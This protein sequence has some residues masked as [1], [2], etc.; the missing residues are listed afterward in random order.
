MAWLT[1]PWRRVVAG[2]GLVGL[3]AGG[4]FYSQAWPLSG[5]GKYVIIQVTPGESVS[6]LG[7]DLA[8]HKVIGSTLAFRL[9]TAVFGSPT[10]AT[11]FYSIAQNSS[12]STV[13]RIFAQTPNATVIDVRPG[14]TL[15][16]IALNQLASQL[17][18][19]Y[20]TRFL[21][22]A[23]L[24]ALASPFSPGSSLEGLIGT[25]TYLV[26]PGETAEQLVASM[27]KRFLGQAARAGVVPGRDIH[28]LSAYQLVV[29]ASIVEKEGYYTRNMGDVAR[30]IL[31][32]LHRGGGLQMDS[33][34]LYSLHR[35]GGTV[36]SAMLQ[37]DT[38][39]NTYLHSGLTPTPICATSVFAMKSM[40][41]PPAGHWLY[42]TLIS[43]DGKLA[44]AN[45]FAE[46]LA[47]EA[48]GHRA[49][50]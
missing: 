48:I 36:T 32:R 4:W 26:T 10:V 16:E 9:D 11:G 50:V 27:T 45:T 18:P 37:I 13:R 3:V 35:D 30:V 38:P 41:N 1:K 24:A 39:Y 49:G 22:A 15:R 7:S 21:A 12:F 2:F 28:G 29:A 5:P 31:N 34:I 6:A 46:Q 33:T 20:A 40:V 25:G 42:F 43:R 8:A 17:G 47:N 44:F 23:H 14:L 19:A